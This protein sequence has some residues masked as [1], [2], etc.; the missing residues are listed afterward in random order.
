ML[1]NNR[2]SFFEEKLYF[3]YEFL[4]TFAFL[5]LLNWFLDVYE[6][7]N[8]VMKG[9][10]Y[11]LLI[12][13]LQNFSKTAQTIFIKKKKKKKKLREHKCATR[14]MINILKITFTPFIL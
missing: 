2:N 5:G 4:E 11:Y 13:I 12:I 1:L 6:I 3:K 10:F 8:L 9:H 7:W 14:S